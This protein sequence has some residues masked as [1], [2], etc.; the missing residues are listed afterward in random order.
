MMYRNGMRVK[1]A[2]VPSD[3]AAEEL[4]AVQPAGQ[5]SAHD[6]ESAMLVTPLQQIS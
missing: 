2:N 6:A 4:L 5:F 1:D 3:H